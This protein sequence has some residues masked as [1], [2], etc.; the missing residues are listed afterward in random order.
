V[1]EGSGKRERGEIREERAE[2]GRR[3]KLGA[4]GVRRLR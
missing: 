3:W 1:I 4:S 2:G